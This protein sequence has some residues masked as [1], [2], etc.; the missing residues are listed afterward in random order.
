LGDCE[1][2]KLADQATAPVG[3]VTPFRRPREEQE[4]REQEKRRWTDLVI[5]DLDSDAGKAAA[6]EQHVAPRTV[7]QVMWT[8]ANLD[9]FLDAGHVYISLP[10][11]GERVRNC[12][13]ENMSARHLR[14]AVAVLVARDHL[15]IDPRPGSSNLM[16]PKYRGDTLDMVTG[17]PGHDDRSTP[18]MMSAESSYLNSSTE[19]LSAEEG[20]AAVVESIDPARWFREL[21]LACANAPT[22]GLEGPAWAAWRDLSAIDQRHIRNLIGASGGIDIGRVWLST[23]IQRREWEHRPL[24]RATGRLV[25]PGTPQWITERERRLAAR[26]NVS[27]MDQQGEQGKPWSC[28]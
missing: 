20:G 26:L 12:Y 18:D 28:G 8:I 14:R 23:W 5:A 24:P 16:R 13:D 3:R 4:R 10:G 21:W 1:V 25:W 15:S 7:K 6:R 22:R 2:T 27:F 19:T 11:L 17:D 9:S